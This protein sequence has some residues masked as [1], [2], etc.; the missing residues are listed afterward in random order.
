MAKALEFASQPVCAS[1]GFHGNGAGRAVCHQR[2][3]LGPCCL[4]APNLVP[5]SVLRMKEEAVF[6]QIDTHQRRVCHD[7]L[8]EKETARSAYADRAVSVRLTIS[9]SLAT[10]VT[11]S[12]NADPLHL[13]ETDVVPSGR[14]A[15]WGASEHGWPLSSQ[16]ACLGVN[17][18]C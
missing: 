1:T 6:A 15:V 18:L 2:I 13:D 11:L 16:R 10:S 5:M 8:P 3:Q 12:L 14:T 7:G 17:A 9:L 4:L